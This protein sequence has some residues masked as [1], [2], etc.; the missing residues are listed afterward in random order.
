MAASLLPRC[1]PCIVQALYSWG[2]ENKVV[3]DL[4]FI[5]GDTI[6]ALNAGDGQWWFGRLRRNRTTGVFPSNFVKVLDD[7]SIVPRPAGSASRCRSTTPS[8]ELS[9]SRPTTPYENQYLTRATTP[10]AFPGHPQSSM[11]CIPPTSRSPSPELHN[12]RSPF[13][14]NRYPRSSSPPLYVARSP[15]P[16]PISR[17]SSAQPHYSRA[18]SPQLCYDRPTSPQSYQGRTTNPLD[19][20]VPP[21]HQQPRVRSPSPRLN[22][23]PSPLRFAMQDVLES[24]E[25]LRN[26][27]PDVSASIPY[28][29]DDKEDTEDEQY[30]DIVPR[31]PNTSLGHSTKSAWR[32]SNGINQYPEDMKPPVPLT[33]AERMENKILRIEEGISRS[34]DPVRFPTPAPPPHRSGTFRSNHSYQ[35]SVFS[36]HSHST[37]ATSISGCSAAS[38]ASHGRCKRTMDFGSVPSE[39][40]VTRS[41]TNFDR[42]HTSMSVMGPPPILKTKKSGLMKGKM[43]FTKILGVGN[44][45]I[46]NVHSIQ[47]TGAGWQEARRDVNRSN[48]PSLK[49]REEKWRNIELEGYKVLEPIVILEQEVDGDENANGG[50]VESNSRLNIDKLNFSLVDKT[51]RYI[52][53]LP[54]HSTP[55]NLATGLICRPYRNDIQRLRAIFVF[56]AEKISWENGMLDREDDDSICRR[57]LKT[58]RAS[59]D[60]LVVVMRAMCEGI[61]I[62]CEIIR[63]YIKSKFGIHIATDRT[64][65]GEVIDIDSRLKSNHVW[66][67]VLVEGE[68]RIIDASLAS[69]T[70]PRQRQF[71]NTAAAESFFFLTPPSN[72][73]YTHLPIDSRHQHIIPPLSREIL[74]SLPYACPA[75]FRYNLRLVNFYTS[76]LR[77]KDLECVQID[78]QVPDDVECVVETEARAFTTDLEGDIFDGGDLERKPGLSQA[79]WVNNLKIFRVKGILPGDQARGVLNVYAGKK[80]LM[81]SIKDNPHSIALAIPISHTGENAP[82]SFVPRHPTPHAMRH[83]LYIRQ[84]QCEFLHLNNTYVFSI[85]QFPSSKLCIT[86]PA[87]LALQLPSGKLVKLQQNK[88]D[89]EKNTWEV[90][91][92]IVEP[93]VYRGLVLSERLSSYCV[94][95][96]WKCIA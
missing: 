39:Q 85:R 16:K 36:G 65:P 35:Q 5:E 45:N 19:P 34:G 72:A 12:N 14:Q 29:P 3:G 70:H 61:E 60:E 15:S 53:T 71:S 44:S 93:G 21:P 58:R 67:A 24:L 52:T 42:P 83:D 2:G 84:P 1:F 73:L 31:R 79:M 10:H 82:Y 8:R 64:A 30:D 55:A 81:H 28:H 48:S 27:S 63:G 9:K 80:G 33:Y 6:E 78:I 57:V 95:A 66:N 17:A 92:K 46:K 96:E 62:P 94:F 13:A 68:W 77:L 76:L 51:T 40:P 23:T 50:V 38:G 56:L 86:K 87:K 59:S 88:Y 89:V 26:P 47:P 69:P 11:Q 18:S 4:G 91:L 90:Q 25:G 20:P 54:P 22:R 7:S 75:F 43:I 32:D 41:T 37:N 74:L 49:E